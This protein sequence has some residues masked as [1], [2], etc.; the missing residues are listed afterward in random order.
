MEL[1]NEILV[2]YRNSRIHLVTA[3]S[4]MFKEIDEI[5]NQSRKN[6]KFF[7]LLLII[8]RTRRSVT[9]FSKKSL[10]SSLFQEL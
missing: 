5:K 8:I 7:E 9:V 3:Y 10:L 6:C 2:Q 1:L 4:F